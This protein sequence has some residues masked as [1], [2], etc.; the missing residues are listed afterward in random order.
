MKMSPSLPTQS[1]ET[2]NLQATTSSRIQ[3]VALGSKISPVAHVS[4]HDSKQPSPTA[5]RSRPQSD[6]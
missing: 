2:W 3:S 4:K 5:A 1:P 6:D